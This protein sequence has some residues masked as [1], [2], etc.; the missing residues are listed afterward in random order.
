[1]KSSIKAILIILG[2][3]LLFAG[4]ILV[5]WHLS[6]NAKEK[7]K[8]THIADV[9]MLQNSIKGD[10]LY[11]VKE[12]TYRDSA[13][14]I[15]VNNPEKTGTDAYFNRKYKLNEYDNINMV[16]IYP[17]DSAKPLKSASFDDA[18]MATGKKLGQFQIEWVAKYIDTLDGSCKPLKK[19]LKS[20]LRD[21]DSF[22]NE[23]TV[24][25]PASIHK[26]QVICKFR[27]KDSLDSK[28]LHEVTAVVDANGN[29]ISTEK[30]K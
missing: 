28:F 1:M 17:Y 21:P 26:M 13:I 25:Q 12:V 24:Y 30:I 5:K 23:E 7:S 14:L 10:S 22:K 6:S 20:T 3:I 11:E 29:L 8:G 19:Y 18:P 2:A 9:L 4:L 15:A 16:Y 27:A